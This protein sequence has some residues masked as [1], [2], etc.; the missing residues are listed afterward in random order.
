MSTLSLPV[1]PTGTETHHRVAYVL[2]RRRY[3]FSFYTSTVDDAWFFN[4]ANDDGSVVI[5][6]IALASGVDLLHPYRHL[7]VPPG[8]LWVHDVDLRG[9][10]PDLRAF[11][12]GRAQLRYLEVLT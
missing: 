5:N 3:R 7:A 1:Q 11:A 9:A 6:G 4:L 12:E 8:P 2:D 10:D